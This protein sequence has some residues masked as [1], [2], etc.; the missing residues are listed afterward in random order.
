[1]NLIDSWLLQLPAECHPIEQEQHNGQ[2]E[3]NNQPEPKPK[4]T[5][6]VFEKIARLGRF[7]LSIEIKKKHRHGKEKYCPKNKPKK[8]AT[9]MQFVLGDHGLL[10]K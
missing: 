5:A 7:K 9:I 4:D 3:K 10:V 8:T 1:M 6:I 2:G